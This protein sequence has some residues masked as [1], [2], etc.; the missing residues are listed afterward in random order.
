MGAIDLL[1]AIAEHYKAARLSLLLIHTEAIWGFL[2]I[3]RFR[4]KSSE[5]SILRSHERRTADGDAAFN[6]RSWPD[7]KC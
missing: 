4:R 2:L 1:A 3:T 5:R 6:S 7:E